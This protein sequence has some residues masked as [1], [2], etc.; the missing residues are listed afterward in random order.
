MAFEQR[1]NTGAVFKN[2]KK[3]TENHPDGTGSALIEGVE[4]WVSMWLKKG[5]KGD[6]RSLAFT[7]KDEK[8]KKPDEEIPF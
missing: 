7:R 6:F 8:L 3:T 1:P 4:Y 5:A 2:D